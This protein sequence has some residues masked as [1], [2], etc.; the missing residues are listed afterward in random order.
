MFMFQCHLEI[1]KID[2]FF[3]KALEKITNISLRVVHIFPSIFF[4]FLFFFVKNFQN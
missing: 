4:M 2:Y 1:K 3:K